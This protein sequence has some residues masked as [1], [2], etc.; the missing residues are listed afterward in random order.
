M[1]VYSAID[2]GLR[3]CKVGVVI[4]SPSFFAKDWPQRELHALAALAASEGRDKI[5]PVWH[6]VGA[7]EVARYSPLLA[8]VYA[9]KMQDGV[10]AVIEQI[11][12]VLRPL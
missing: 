1:S 8:G 4:I 2:D 5:L 11:A 7:S 10:P 6:E 9:A 12:R 3:R